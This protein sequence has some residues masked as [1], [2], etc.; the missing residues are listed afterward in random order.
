MS[1]ID[2][3]DPVLRRNVDP[4]ETNLAD[5]DPKLINESMVKVHFVFK[6]I[7]LLVTFSPGVK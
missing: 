6:C 2:E 4:E 1:E 7:P 5:R 3:D